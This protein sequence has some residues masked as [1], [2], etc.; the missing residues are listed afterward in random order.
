LSFTLD[1]EGKRVSARR[2]TFA[3]PFI[4]GAL[5]LAVWIIAKK[6]MKSKKKRYPSL[7]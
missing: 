2:P 7:K 6:V 5:G 1:E 3:F 4:G